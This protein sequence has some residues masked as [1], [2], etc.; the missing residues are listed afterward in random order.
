MAGPEL[1][2]RLL[3][4]PPEV[5]NNIYGI[6]FKSVDPVPCLPARERKRFETNDIEVDEL[7]DNLE[8]YTAFLRTCHQI[9]SEAGGVLYGANRFRFAHVHSVKHD[10][11]LDYIAHAS[12]KWFRLIRHQIGLLRTAIITTK[13]ATEHGDSRFMNIGQKYHCNFNILLLLLL[14]WSDRG[15]NLRIVFKN[16]VNVEKMLSITNRKQM[17]RPVDTDTLQMT[18]T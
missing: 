11:N 1:K 14:Y 9:Y 15:K 4:L 2:G 8:D 5:R 18:L 3:T 17:F 16:P 10:R 12:A 7:P 13:N 6:M